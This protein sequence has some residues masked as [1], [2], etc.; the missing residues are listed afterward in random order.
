MN[1]KAFGKRLLRR[2]EEKFGIKLNAW[3]V[4]GNSLDCAQ[5]LDLV[6]AGDLLKLQR[7]FLINLFV[8][9]VKI[10]I[11]SIWDKL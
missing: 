9:S 1:G 6:M 5:G 10:Y 3:E 4:D 8:N 7:V 11:C 2:Y